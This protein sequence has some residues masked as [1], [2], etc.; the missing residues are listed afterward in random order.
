MSCLFISL[1]KLLNIDPTTLRNQI[2]NY[3]VENPDAEWDGTKLSEWIQMVAGDRYQNVSQYISEMRRQSQWGG[4]PEIAVCCMI[5]NVAVEI[6]NLRR[7]ASQNMV[8]KNTKSQ[9]NPDKS[10]TQYEQTLHKEYPGLTR[11]KYFHN[12]HPLRVN[13]ENFMKY[14]K[15][16][17]MNNLKKVID[18]SEPSALLKISWTGSHYE[19]VSIKNHHRQ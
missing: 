7:P 15:Q 19:P 14:K 2:C 3:I 13:Y 11:M 6:V 10:W 1:G 18:D 17:Y 8:F 12:N 9:T 4:A 5:Y 16:D